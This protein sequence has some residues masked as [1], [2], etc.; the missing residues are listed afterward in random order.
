MEGYLSSW[1]KKQGI[2]LE[3]DTQQAHMAAM[4]RCPE[5]FGHFVYIYF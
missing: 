4:V 5:T 1:Q 2:H 3:W